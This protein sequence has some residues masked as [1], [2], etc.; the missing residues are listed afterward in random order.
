MAE[1]ASAFGYYEAPLHSTAGVTYMSVWLPLREP[2]PPLGQYKF[3]I[4]MPKKARTMPS[5]LLSNGIPAFVTCCMPQMDHAIPTAS[6]KLGTATPTMI[7]SRSN[8]RGLVVI[9]HG[10][11]DGTLVLAH[12]GERL[13]SLGFIVAVPSFS[14]SHSNDMSPP[15]Q[16]GRSFAIEQTAL[17]VATMDACIASIRE[18]YRASLDDTVPTLLIGY[19]FG[20]DT[21]RHMSLACPRLYVGGPG[22]HK[23]FVNDERPLPDIPPPAGP[24]TQL[25]TTNDGNMRTLKLTL[26]E[27][28]D[29]TGYGCTT[30]E[31]KIV[32]STD[33][34][35]ARIKEGGP[36]A[37]HLRIDL[38]DV[39]HGEFKYPPYTEAERL[40]WKKALCG[41]D[42]FNKWA[43][44]VD[45]SIKVQRCETAAAVMIRWVLAVAG[46][47]EA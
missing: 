19:S 17:R 22:W 28:S 40:M 8:I 39:M 11:T 10:F 21:I 16:Y 9:A 25:L 27:S 35:A 13:A 23:R 29:C 20:A 41:I 12:L 4:S 34:L 44:P 26:D 6:P 24:S 5:S 37:Q 2:T 7:A 18:T 38:E 32:A 1:Q 15:I 42:P 47:V 14:D 43:T 46:G 36:D 31:R 3:N 45:P 30:N 33:E